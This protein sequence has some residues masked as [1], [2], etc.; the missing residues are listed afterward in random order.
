MD[1]EQQ[2]INLLQLGSRMS[3]HYYK[4]PMLICNSGGKDSLVLLELARRAGIPYE[5]QH[6]H[7]TA[8]APETVRYV[9]QQ[10]HE[11]EL[12]GVK[13]YVNMP[14]YKGERTS[15]W[16]LIG[17]KPTREGLIAMLREYA[18]WAEANINDVPIMLPDDLRAAADMLEKG[19]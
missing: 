9:R 11:L 2:A 8:D 18:E 17:E 1:K 3:L 15:M 16:K 6:S 14:T 5:V 13:C 7:T 12:A 4:Q 10:M 19:E